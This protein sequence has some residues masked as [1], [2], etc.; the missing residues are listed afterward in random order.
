MK[1]LLKYVLLVVTM[2]MSITSFGQLFQ[3]REEIIRN[4]VGVSFKTDFTKDGNRFMYYEKPM[5]SNASGNYN[6]Y[7][8]MYF[9]N[10]ENGSEICVKWSV[11][12]PASETNSNVAYFKKKYVEIG[13]MRWKDYEN[14]I[15]Y[16]IE[17]KDGM[18]IVTA[19]WDDKQ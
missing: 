18:C 10:L 3:S 4:N 17:V 7:K 11:I 6:L 12:E 19:W 1:F 5:K 16:D 9:L 2:L 13:Y 8:A 14:N 15:I